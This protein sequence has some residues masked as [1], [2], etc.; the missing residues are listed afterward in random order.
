M[1]ALDD[2]IRHCDEAC[3]HL[4]IRRA[5]LSTKLFND[6]KRLEQIAGGLS[7]IGYRRLREAESALKD[8]TDFRSRSD[9]GHR[10]SK[11]KS[12]PPE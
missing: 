1:D 4:R 11:A 12:D 5:T 7:D 8:L 3:L 6:G 9:L 10:R 2:F